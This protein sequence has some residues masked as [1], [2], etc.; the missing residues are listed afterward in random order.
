[1]FVMPA[2]KGTGDG[3]QLYLY[4]DELELYLYD[5]GYCVQLEQGCPNSQLRSTGSPQTGPKLKGRGGGCKDL[6]AL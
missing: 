4:D 3:M 6:C 2:L 1:M 5:R